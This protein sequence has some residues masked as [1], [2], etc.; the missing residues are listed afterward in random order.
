MSVQLSSTSLDFARPLT[1]RQTRSFDVTNA[2]DFWVAFKVKTNYTEGYIVRPNK[3]RL[4]PGETINVS[5]KTVPMEEEPPA[6]V[7]CHHKFRVETVAI[8]DEEDGDNLQFKDEHGLHSKKIQVH[9]HLPPEDGG[10][11]SALEVII[12]FSLLV[13]RRRLPHQVAEDAH[14]WRS[15]SLE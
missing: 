3:G 14:H 11:S 15:V 8:E 13:F 2:N 7:E 6:D 5:V 1:Q 12:S 10:L 9:Y 4:G